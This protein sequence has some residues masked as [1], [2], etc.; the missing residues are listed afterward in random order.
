MQVNIEIV[1]WQGSE[2]SLIFHFC[3][4]SG[5]LVYRKDPTNSAQSVSGHLLF[6]V[7]TAQEVKGL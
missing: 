7:D 1:D 4:F 6:F 3:R 5:P 2:G